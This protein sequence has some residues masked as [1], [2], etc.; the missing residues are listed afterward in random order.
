MDWIHERD[1]KGF[2]HRLV[3]KHLN[4][5]YEWA[6]YETPAIAPSGEKDR[7]YVAVTDYYK[8]SPE[9][10]DPKMLYMVTEIA[11]FK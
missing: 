11:Q 6:G 4:Q 1:A 5:A 3:R 8:G 7:W 9:F 2:K 10:P